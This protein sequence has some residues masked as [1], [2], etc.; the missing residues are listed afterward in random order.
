MVIRQ[1]PKVSLKLKYQKVI[2]LALVL[3]LAILVIVFQA[4]KRFEK[5]VG[6]QENV[7]IVIDVQYVCTSR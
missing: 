5:K 7:S 4:F 1:N 3:S 6:E 2:E